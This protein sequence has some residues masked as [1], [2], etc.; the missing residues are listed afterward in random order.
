[1]LLKFRVIGSD[2]DAPSESIVEGPGAL[3]IAPRLPAIVNSNQAIF[4][5]IR[6]EEAPVPQQ[7][8]FIVIG[9]FLVGRDLAAV[10]D[11]SGHVVVTYRRGRALDGQRSYRRQLVDAIL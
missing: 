10:R 9:E 5:I 3:A 7:V 2:L 4:E 6:I 1:M 11:L 8:P